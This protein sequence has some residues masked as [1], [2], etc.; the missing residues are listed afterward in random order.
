MPDASS[1]DR[2]DIGR[3]YQAIL[4]LSDALSR[5]QTP[6]NFTTILAEQMRDCLQFLQFHIVVYEEKS[7]EIQWTVVGRQERLTG[8]PVR[9]Q[10]SVHAYLSQEPFCIRDW[11]NDERIP[12]ILKQQISDYGCDVGLLAFVPL[13]TAYQLLGMLAVSGA[14]TTIYSTEDTRFLQL[15]SSIVA[16]ALSEAF[17]LRNA[18]AARRESQHRNERLRRKERELRE[19]IESIPAMPWSASADGCADFFNKHW[20]DYAGLAEDQ[21]RGMGWIAALHP[22]HRDGLLKYWEVLMLS[23]QAG[24][25]E[26]KLRRSDGEYHWFLFRAT[27]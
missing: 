22:N 24:E 14:P 27:P 10:S 13:T 3:R 17:N 16:S 26:A 1:T 12:A 2:G 23:R 4:R 8:V 21:A 18:D 6:E 9:H 20:L 19:V 5:C 15:I 25:Y 7:N 11:E